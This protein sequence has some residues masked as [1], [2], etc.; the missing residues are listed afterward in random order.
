M[1]GRGFESRR[2]HLLSK[3]LNKK[4]P[5]ASG[6]FCLCTLQSPAMTEA[7]SFLLGNPERPKSDCS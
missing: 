7:M 2:L 6:V 3:I 4:R 1:F 5:T